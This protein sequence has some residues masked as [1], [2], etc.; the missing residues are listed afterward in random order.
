MLYMFLYYSSYILQSHPCH[1]QAL[2]ERNRFQLQ[3][4]HDHHE[5]ELIFDLK[6]DDVIECFEECFPLLLILLKHSH[7]IFQNKTRS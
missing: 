6:K 4:L 5:E 3:L 7:P 1:A 2:Y